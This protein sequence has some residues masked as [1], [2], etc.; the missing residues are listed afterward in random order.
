MK[1]ELLSTKMK[2]EHGKMLALLNNF[3]KGDVDSLNKLK[4]IQGRHALAEERAIM[5]LYNKKKD[6]VLLNTI[7]EQHT[8]LKD[9]LSKIEKDK[10]V[11]KLFDK[12][13]KTHIKIEDSKFYPMLDKDFTIEEQEELFKKFLFIFNQK[14]SLK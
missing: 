9:Y 10:S 6:F 7:L 2:L 12:L 11:A 14:I 5:S 8:Q 1:K 13:M 3:M 4:D